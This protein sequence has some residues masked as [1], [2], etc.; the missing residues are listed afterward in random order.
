MSTN[1]T[2]VWLITGSSTGFGRILAQQLLE[3][4]EIVVATARKPEQLEDLVSN[5]SDRTVMTSKHIIKNYIYKIGEFE[6]VCKTSLLL[7]RGC[8][9]PSQATDKEQIF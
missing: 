7:G 2:K 6:G 3:R 8:S 4:G 9:T 5:Y 1:K